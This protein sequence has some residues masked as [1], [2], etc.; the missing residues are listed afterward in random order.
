M[1]SDGTS[2]RELS[3]PHNHLGESLDEVAKG[4]A[5]GTISRGTAIKL[6]G[7]ALLG[8]IGLLSLFP[9]VA[10]AEGGCEGVPA[11]NDRR[12]PE[13]PCGNCPN[14]LCARTVSGR[15]RCLDFTEAVCPER[16]ECDRNRD[17]PGDAVCIQVA[18]CCGS[19]KNLCVPPCPSECP[20]SPPPPIAPTLGGARA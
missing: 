10:G 2:R 12:C 6:S 8:S 5:E 1:P 20:I 15:K 9:G 16:D 14:C 17:C 18:G 11:I 19:R 4:L 3:F 13:S 7:A